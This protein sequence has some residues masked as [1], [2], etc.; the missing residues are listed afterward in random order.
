MGLAYFLA[1][2]ERKSIEDGLQNT[3][4]ALAAAVDRELLDSVHT[5]E[6][7]AASPVFDDVRIKEAYAFAQSVRSTHPGWHNILLH[8]PD[9]QGLFSLAR[10]FGFPL[11]IIAED[12]SFAQV[13]RTKR[14]AFRN[15][16][17]AP[18][19]GPSS[20]IR[21][22]VIRNG[23]IKYVLTVV[24]DENLLEEILKAQ[25]LPSSWLGTI[26]D[27]DKV[28]LAR[29]HD[30]EQLIG[31]P[32]SPLL[33]QISA[34]PGEGWLKGAT[35]QGI[36][37]YA[38]YSRSPVTG[39]SVAITVPTNILD[40]PLQRSFLVIAGL[41]AL[42]I[43]L[44]VSLAIFVSGGIARFVQFITRST[45]ALGED[46]RIEV[47]SESSVL[48]AQRITQA[49]QDAA[50][51]LHK[52]A[53]E[54][55]DVEREL[56]ASE[57]HFHGLANAVPVMMWEADTTKAW[58]YFN[59][60][61]L[62][63]TGR[64]LAQESGIGW[65]EGVH[66]EDFERCLK[67]YTEAFDRRERFK[68]E[69]R[70]RRADGI[71]RWLGGGGAPLFGPDG[72]FRGYV[73]GCVDISERKQAEEDLRRLSSEL[74]RRVE[75]RTGQLQEEIQSRKA[76]QENLGRQAELLDLT[77]DA[78]FVRDFTSGRIV[79]WNRG[80]SDLYGWSN[81]EALGKISNKLL[82]TKFPVS[83]QDIEA[84]IETYGWWDGELIQTAKDGKQLAV[85]SRWSLR[86]DINGN[87]GDILELNYDVTAKKETERK[88]REN[89][90]LA[91]LGTTAAVFAHEI[92]NPLNGISASLQLLNSQIRHRGDLDLKLKSLIEHATDEINRLV[93]LL[94]D[95]RSFARP[96]KFNL[97]PTDLV[98]VVDDIVTL[99]TPLYESIGIQVKR[100]FPEELRT[101]MADPEKIKQAILNVAKNAVEAMPSGGVLTFRAYESERRV[102]L[103]ISDTGVGIP[104]GTGVFQLFRTTK[105]Q[106]S[107]LGLPVTGQIISGHSGTI[108][109]VSEIGKGTTFK[110]GL[111]PGTC[112]PD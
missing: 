90:R 84:A 11:R 112:N 16:R 96:Q 7:I 76:A 6:A 79:F 31:E 72:A 52:R 10:P 66:P 50:L 85:E 70:L 32:A 46:G 33:Q 97:E 49:L 56:R 40:W 19:S 37:A 107:G 51:L 61:W 64:T 39:W 14:P 78:I 23:E 103:E 110:I 45:R 87:P 99:E 30:A 9:R 55:D 12:Q 71:Y 25:R 94:R 48:E 54:R 80:A 86:R 102:V 98:K 104:E 24:F 58:I 65:T 1:Q 81:E 3:T 59:E 18:V 95:F 8:D 101:V 93:S 100:L 74:E 60:P 68:M 34:Q 108:G 2:S 4:R 111:P 53:V 21:A 88:L 28:I 20:G 43:S 41:G 82:E 13:L 22:P 29:T 105:P 67:I 109:Y 47:P 69:Y 35:R 27:Q 89:E 77:H 83:L 38:V 42:S 106:G 44:A 26:L 91:T 57:A 92:S 36:S 73:G 62:N 17:D 75:E 5:L 15:F 63:F